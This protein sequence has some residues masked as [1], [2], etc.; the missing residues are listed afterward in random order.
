MIFTLLAYSCYS[1]S[2]SM[3]SSKDKDIDVSDEDT[4]ELSFKKPPKV[5]KK[6]AVKNQDA[7]YSSEL[8][9]IDEKGDIVFVKVF[10]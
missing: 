1:N 8:Y 5:K 9:R 3:S 10:M 4:D 2:T 7:F 6:K